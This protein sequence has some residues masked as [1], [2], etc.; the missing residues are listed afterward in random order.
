MLPLTLLIL[1]ICGIASGII[2]SGKGRSGFGWFLIGF[3]FGPIGFLAS[4]IVSKEQRAPQ[5]SQGVG[6]DTRTCPHCAETVKRQAKVCRYCGGELPEVADPKLQQKSADLLGA[7]AQG[8]GFFVERL[9]KEG[10]DPNVADDVGVTPLMHAAR[11]GD[12]AMVQQL[13]NAGADVAA[14]DS[15]G[16]G[17]IDYAEMA[18]RTEVAEQLRAAT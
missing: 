16:A 17:A 8:S 10:A 3:L 6:S 18:N 15:G 14:M 11:H 2:A 1:I 5:V 7:A 13:L 9:L 4:L 12:A